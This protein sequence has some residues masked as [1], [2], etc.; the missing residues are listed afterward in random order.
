[1]L[2]SLSA[3]RGCKKCPEYAV[4][5]QNKFYVSYPLA[6]VVKVFDKTGV[7]LH[8]IGC[9]GLNDG[10]LL[11]P[12]GLVVDKHNQLIVCDVVNRRLQLFTLS[13]KFLSKL[14]GEYFKDNMPGFAALSNNGNLF[15][16]DQFGNLIF[17]FN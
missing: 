1:M 5:H 15:V 16:A 11:Y 8:N 7:Y 10:Q 17:A 12:S 14:E 6:H 3:P 2:L 9:K 13:G 4:F